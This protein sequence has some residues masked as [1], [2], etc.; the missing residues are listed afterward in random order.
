MFDHTVAFSELAANN[1]LEIGAGRPRSAGLDRFPLPILRV[2]D[3]VDGGILPALMKAGPTSRSQ[4][5]GPKTSRP[6]DIV[7]TTKGTVGRVAMM[8]IERQTFAYSPQLCYFRP[9]VNGPL[10][11]RY[12]Y[13]WFKSVEFWRQADALKGQTDM[14]DFLSLAD[15]CSLIIRLPSLGEQAAVADV[16]GALDDKIA[17]S[18]RIHDLAEKLCSAEVQKASKGGHKRQ[19]REVL[20][21]HYGKALPASERVPGDVVVY[22]SGGITG[23]HSHPLVDH[24]GVIVG[25][26]GTVGS[27]YWAG[28]PHF[29]IDT[30]YYVEPCEKGT[31]EILYYVLQ[32]AP[33]TEFNSDSA[34]PGLNRDEAYSCQVIFPRKESLDALS[35][36]LRDRFAWMK[37][38]RDETQVLAATRNELLPLLMS[39]KIRVRDAEKV[40]EGVV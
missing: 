23:M 24:P 11:A 40:V 39:G 6:G 4:E 8:P 29:P 1:L 15:I 19:L 12:L 14:A 16:L 33:L 20:K 34:V 3:V 22:G 36:T 30:T 18:K 17:A 13:Y 2:A 9:A 37:A 7:L 5:V 26:K 21:L 32:S 35:R 27:V 10:K 38:V 28:G 31:D 25:R